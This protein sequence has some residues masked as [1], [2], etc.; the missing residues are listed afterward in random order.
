MTPGW[1][2]TRSDGAPGVYSASGMR[3]ERRRRPAAN[4]ALLFEEI[5]QAWRHQIARDSSPVIATGPWTVTLGEDVPRGTVEGEI[6]QH[7]SGP[8]GFGYDPLFYYPPFGCTFGE[9]DLARKANVSHRGNALR[10]MFEFLSDPPYSSSITH[11]RYGAS[12]CGRLER[13]RR[14][15]GLQILE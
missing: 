13:Q 15:A 12:R 6:A 9:A 5:L 10:L 11:M 4:N 3:G 14:I 8:H 2:W 7:E 1:R